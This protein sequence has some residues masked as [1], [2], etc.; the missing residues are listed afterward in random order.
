M[1]GYFHSE[2]QVAHVVQQRL[3][4]TPSAGLSTGAGSEE[5]CAVC[6]WP[7]RN[8]RVSIE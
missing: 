7:L 4:N 5:G 3:Y 6:P 2:S 1:G 8:V